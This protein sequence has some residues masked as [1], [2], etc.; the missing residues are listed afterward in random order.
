MKTLIL[1]DYNN[2][3]H[4]CVHLKQIS[5]SATD[6]SWGLLSYMVF[7]IMYDFVMDTVE[8]MDEGD[9]VD[10][11]L[12]LDDAING[13]WRRDIYP[14][15]KADRAKKRAADDIDWSRAYTEF[16]K[17]ADTIGRYTPWKVMRVPKCEADDIIYTLAVNHE[18]G[19]IVHSGDSDYLQLVS[20]NI[21]LYSATARDYVDFPHTCRV[22][23]TQVHC[24]SP[25]EYLVYA[26]LTGQGGKDNV[27]NVKTPTDWDTESG[28]RKPGFG[29]AAVT[30]LLKSGK[31]LEDALKDAGLW[32]NY[33]RNKTLIDMREIPYR[34]RDAI[35]AAFGEYM[36]EAADVRGMLSEY[37][38][39]S[40][41]GVADD[42]SVRL[43][44]AADGVRKIECEVSTDFADEETCEFVL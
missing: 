39:P 25:E 19:V 35:L 21:L 8:F 11:V 2:L 24:K 28:K 12:A 15:Y 9:S 3:A 4:R 5:G 44:M 23:G 33:L 30:K 32:D 20:E 26:V 38:W 17:L 41:Y 14:P 10:V 29:V 27:Y 16:N 31:P 40:I 42:M 37:D 34:Y 1:F 13:Y 36:P 7:N 22:A 6:E 18:G 43:Q